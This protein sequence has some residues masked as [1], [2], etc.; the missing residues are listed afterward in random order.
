MLAGA[1]RGALHNLGALV[2]GHESAGP[3]E[4]RLSRATFELGPERI[5]AQ[6]ERDVGRVLVVGLAD[7][8]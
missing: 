5:G 7:D 3:Q 8:T 2:A 6:Q 1:A 4:E